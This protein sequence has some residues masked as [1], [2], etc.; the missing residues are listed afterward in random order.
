M[1]INLKYDIYIDGASKGNPGE[2]GIGVSIYE[3]GKLLKNLSEYI[4]ITTNN[5]AE[6][7]AL[8][9][10]LQEAHMQKMNHV[11]INTDSQLLCRQINGEYKVKDTNLK[12]LHKIATHL[13]S[14]LKNIEIVN[15]PREKNRSA[16]KLAT[17]AVEK[18]PV[19]LKKHK[20]AMASQDDQL[21]GLI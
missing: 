10:A 1:T 8:I 17:I 9:F 4:G 19:L 7:T 14:G 20:K 12:L 3:G 6:Y 18:R 11:K 21:F 16:D 2:S 5:V 15:I 13:I